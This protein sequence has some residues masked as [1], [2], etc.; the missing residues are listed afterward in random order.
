MFLSTNFDITSCGAV[1]LK[2]RGFR[3][4]VVFFQ[5]N[6][7]RLCNFHFWHINVGV[8]VKYSVRR[9][10]S[11]KFRKI[12]WFLHDG[13]IGDIW[14]LFKNRPYFD[15]IIEIMIFWQIFRKC[16]LFV[17]S[18]KIKLSDEIKDMFSKTFFLHY[19]VLF[20]G[21]WRRPHTLRIC[22]S[23]SR[24]SS[25]PSFLEHLDEQLSFP[26]RPQTHR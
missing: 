8:F 10:H 21:K 7:Y 22:I 14:K 23:A 11:K 15:K 25:G 17:F 9:I 24:M 20:T 18:R 3:D 13:K 2:S 19:R 16:Q 6:S 4:L 5:N 1:F 26:K 12:G